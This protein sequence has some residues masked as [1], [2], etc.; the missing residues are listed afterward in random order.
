M[1]DHM[2]QHHVQH[3]FR[4]HKGNKNSYK[5]CHHYGRYGHIRNFC[6]KLYGYPQSY[7]HPRP[8]KRKAKKTQAKKVWKSN[9]TVKCLLAHDF[10][11]VF[12][13]EDWYFDNGCSHHMNGERGHIERLKT[14][15]SS[16]V[17]LFHEGRRKIKGIGKL[18]FPCLPNLDNVL[19]VEG[20]ITNFISISQLCD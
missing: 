2:S 20:L 4:H 12:L 7:K 8:N 5:R 3:V 6:Y 9:E 15:S 1:K 18:V 19:L 14:Q 10:P 11:R 16:Y 13:R 17:T